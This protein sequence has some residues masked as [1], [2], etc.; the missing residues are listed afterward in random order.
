MEKDHEVTV[1][2]KRVLA[3]HKV[4]E[5]VQHSAYKT[6]KDTATVTITPPNEELVKIITDYFL[7]EK[8]PASIGAPERYL[9]DVVLINEN[10]IIG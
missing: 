7:S 6:V 3:D 8:I 2:M 5:G 10:T 1:V 9:F 4:P